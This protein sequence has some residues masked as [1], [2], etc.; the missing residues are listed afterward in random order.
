MTGEGIKV[1]EEKGTMIEGT[2]IATEKGL[3]D[4][5]SEMTEI[6][7]DKTGGTK[8]EEMLFVQGNYTSLQQE[9]YS[10]REIMEKLRASTRPLSQR[11]ETS[12]ESTISSRR[13]SSSTPYERIR[14]RSSSVT[15]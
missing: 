2:E 7:T 11:S 12:R 5:R 3:I 15:R 8:E 14:R 1:A 13:T 9:V 10:M 4:T 6:G